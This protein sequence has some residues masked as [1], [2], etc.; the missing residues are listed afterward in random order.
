MAFSFEITLNGAARVVS[1]DPDDLP[2]AFF[3]DVEE[4][5]ASGKF[6]PIIKAYAGAFGLTTEE[7]RALTV[8][9]FKQLTEG[10]KQAVSVPLA[11]A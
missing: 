8:K 11:S 3:E 2:M 6:S 1:I 7:R 4:A 9:Q 5:Q 10:I